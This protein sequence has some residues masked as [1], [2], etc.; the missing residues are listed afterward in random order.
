MLYYP[1]GMI[2]PGRTYSA[3]NG[4][5]YGFNGKE[6]DNDIAGD[7]YD[8]GA[9]IYDGRIGKFLSMDPLWKDMPFESNF[10]FANN[11]PILMIDKLGKNGEVT[12]VKNA[13]GKG[14][15]MTIT[16]TVYVT[17]HQA[18]ENVEKINN[19]LS[20]EK[21]K[22]A[23]SGTYKDKDGNNWNIN[24]SITYK[25]KEETDKI[26]ETQN[27]LTISDDQTIAVAH[28]WIRGRYYVI[29]AK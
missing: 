13:D 28:L 9:R 3:G 24:L 23:L 5:R 12:I 17:G 15:T 29:L 8:F 6:K 16:T 2:Q 21:S 1:F 18:K 20:S 11:N 25:V 14:G 27:Q 7:H 10:V 4:Y 26:S 19:Y 22:T